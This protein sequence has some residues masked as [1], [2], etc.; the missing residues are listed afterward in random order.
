MTKRYGKKKKGKKKKGT[1]TLFKGITSKIYPYKVRVSRGS[2]ASLQSASALGSINFRLSDLD[3]VADFGG[4]Y[5]MYKIVKLDVK[6]CPVGA[7]RNIVQVVNTAPAVVYTP[8]FYSAI[9][10]DQFDTDANKTLA[11]I[12]QY[13]KSQATMST[14]TCRWSFSPKLRGAV[15]KATSGPTF[16]YTSVSNRW[17]D[18]ADNDV[19]YCGIVYG[20]ESSGG[21]RDSVFQYDIECTYYMLFKGVR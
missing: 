3:S 1:M 2:I 21:A 9:D 10:Y 7:S 16:A 11:E 18:K 8:M 5:D 4:L 13:G 20:M 14:R 12:R 17:L 15:L 19:P 6:F